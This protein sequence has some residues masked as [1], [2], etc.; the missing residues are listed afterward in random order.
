MATFGRL[1]AVIQGVIDSVFNLSS[2]YCA[3]CVF[4]PIDRFPK[5]VAPLWN[6]GQTQAGVNQ[7][8]CSVFVKT[9]NMHLVG[10]LTL[11]CVGSHRFYHKRSH[12]FAPS[13]RPDANIADTANA[14]AFSSIEIGKPNDNP[15]DLHNDRAEALGDR[16][17]QMRSLCKN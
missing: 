6:K 1:Q 12:S 7:Q 8:P 16:D 5:K 17:I 11:E 3:S 14:I 9:G 4:G 15:I 10:S 13:A 2:F